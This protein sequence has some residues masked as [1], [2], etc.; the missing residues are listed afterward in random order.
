M[1]PSFLVSALLSLVLLQQATVPAPPP[2][3]APAA[4][5]KNSDAHKKAVEAGLLLRRGEWKQAEALAK[6][7]VAADPTSAE[8]HYVLGMAYEAGGELEAAETEYKKMGLLAPESLL[9]IS[10]ARIYLRQERVAEAEQQARR[11]V[12][13]NRWVPQ[14][15][16]TLGAVAMRK[17]DYPAAIASFSKAVDLNP[18][19]WNGRLSLAD[20]YR[21]ARRWDEA[22]AH[23]GQA[24]AMKPDHPEALLGKARTWE[25]MGRPAEAISA[26]EKALE[27]AP[28]LLAAQ[29]HLA[30]L[31][32]SVNDAA[33]A[34]PR[35]ALELAE[36]AAEATEWKNAAILETLAEAYERGGEPSRAQE[37]REKVKDLRPK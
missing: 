16:L 7:A 37:I 30:R 20:A 34:K 15:H 14:P 2:A 35:R 21:Q 25:Q 32:L 31:Y 18:R 17:K 12:E 29:L 11:A 5:T 6:E 36:A 19:D 4:D 33:L 8:A 26:Y 23:Y 22:L 28:G 27:A 1:E 13:K 10:L 9:E 24:L 3:P